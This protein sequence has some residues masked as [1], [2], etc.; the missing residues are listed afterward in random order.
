MTA[1]HRLGDL[2][3]DPVFR[4]VWLIGGCGG[5]ARW[6]EMLVVGVFAFEVTGSA[7][8]VALL[9]ILRML[10][11]ALF[12]SVV[13][14]LA[15]RVAPRL[16]LRVGL[17]F[18]ALMSAAV[19][20]LFILELAQYWHVALASFGSG[21]VW[22][23]DMP[24][25]RRILGDVAGRER[26]A[27]AMSLDSATNNA[28][29]MLG[30]LIGGLLYQG[31]G[32][33][34]AFAL[35]AG[36]YGVCVLL[37]FLVPASVSSATRRSGPTKALRDFQE[38]FRYAGRDRDI[39]RIL[40][41]T[42]VFNVWGFP[43]VSMIPVIGSDE[44]SLN[45]GW[46]GALA[47][48]EGAGALLGALVIAVHAKA[49]SFRRLYYFGTGAYLAFV[50]A[51]GCMTAVLPTAAMLFLVGLAGACFTTMQSTLIYS[52]APPEMRGRLFGLLVICIGTGLIGFSN[53]G[54]MA[55]WFG[56][57]TAIRIIAAEGLIPLLLVGLG[58]QQ[59]W[60]R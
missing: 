15:D 36:L 3:A 48:L 24:L 43:F 58:W 51:V 32:T 25:R 5:V 10:P 2:L 39:L 11:L 29:R 49:G 59:L 30:P 57:S 1:P 4:R 16:G 35:S 23:T 27:P 52:V 17:S 38:A 21:L 50:F 13:G 12:G 41:V 20:L 44:L 9:V 7:F 8:L 40:L 33:G 34:G 54:L 47:A 46:I 53:V 55:E 28:T 42:V 26:I 18:A 22:T 60:G 37:V 14:T 6:L 19:S 45:A 56:A 31:L